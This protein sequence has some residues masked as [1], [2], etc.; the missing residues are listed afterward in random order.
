[1]YTHYYIRYKGVYLT[2]K[3]PFAMRANAS[4]SFGSSDTRDLVA[5][6]EC[7]HKKRYNKSYGI[8]CI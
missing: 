6:Y 7:I 4:F 1:M 2:I 8:I 5:V 3:S